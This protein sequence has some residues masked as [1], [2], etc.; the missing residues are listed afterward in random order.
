MILEHNPFALLAL[1]GLLSLLPLIAIATTSYLKL[2]IVLVLVR[3]ALGVQQAPTMLALNAIALVATLFV[4]APTLSACMAQA[5][6]V[7]QLPAS[8]AS[9]IDAALAVVEPLKQ[10]VL[11]NGRPR[12]RERFMEMARQT[13]PE[14]AQRS[15][16]A[17]DWSIAVPAFVVSELQSA[18]EIGLLL[19]IPFVVIDILVSNVLLAMGMQMV[20][21]MIV[22]LPIKLLL[23]VLADGW[24]KLVHA[25]VLSYHG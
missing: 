13:W 7:K 15:A 14:P 4:M 17:D 10:F 20:P 3:N 6:A 22:A 2:S 5:N 9:Q 18:F 8:G 12:E 23:F 24:G 25:L 1:L 16:R 19:F 21:P 11:R